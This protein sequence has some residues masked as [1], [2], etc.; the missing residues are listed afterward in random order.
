MMMAAAAG[1]DHQQAAK[2]IE[3]LISLSLDR[4]T[5]EQTD[6]KLLQQLG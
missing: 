3:M 1:N 6:C 2:L 5:N 4:P